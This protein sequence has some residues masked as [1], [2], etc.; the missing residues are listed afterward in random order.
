MHNN[1]ITN[2]ARNNHSFSFYLSVQH[3]KEQP[4]AD[5]AAWMRHTLM[6]APPKRPPQRSLKRGTTE[7]ESHQDR[8]FSNDCLHFAY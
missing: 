3:G 1:S 8:C 2:T 5:A 7:G 6:Q 4:A